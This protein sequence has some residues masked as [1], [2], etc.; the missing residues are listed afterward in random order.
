MPS[1]RE[2]EPYRNLCQRKCVSEVARADSR[3]LNEQLQINNS[4]L[5]KNFTS[6]FAEQIKQDETGTEIVSHMMLCVL[7]C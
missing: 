6:K 5:A 2:Q 3:E 1:H 7:V 4:L